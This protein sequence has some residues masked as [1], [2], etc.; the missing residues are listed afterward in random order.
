[1]MDDYH[2][3]TAILR[4]PDAVTPHSDAQ[5]NQPCETIPLQDVRRLIWYL[6]Y[7]WISTDGQ[8]EVPG[9]STSRL[10]ATRRQGSTVPDMVSGAT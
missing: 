5:R 3:I 9:S 6:G 1:M 4:M 10:R 2:P 8:S 7:P